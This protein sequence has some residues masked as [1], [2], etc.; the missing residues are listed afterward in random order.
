PEP[1]S[2]EGAFSN[3]KHTWAYG[4]HAAH[5]AVDPKTG[6]VALID[7]VAVENCGRMIH[8]LTLKG[9][10]VGAVVQGLGGAFLEHLAY[11]EN[12]QLLTG[13]PPPFFISAAGRFSKTTGRF[14]GV[15]PP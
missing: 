10:L 1:L 11:D 15:G 6:A 12:G 3:H 5:V 13:S 9:Q 4:A 2:V 8:P 14:W 7:Y